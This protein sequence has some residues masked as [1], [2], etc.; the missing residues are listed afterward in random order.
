MGSAAQ[1]GKIFNRKKQVLPAAAIQELKTAVH[2]E[3]LIKGEPPD[4]IYRAA[5]NRWNKAWIQE[6]VSSLPPGHGYREYIFDEI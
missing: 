1:A 4:E 6:A 5:I 2:G 3:V